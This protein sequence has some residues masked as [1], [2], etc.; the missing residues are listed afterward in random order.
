MAQKIPLNKF[1]SLFTNVQT[2][3]T[4]LYSAP[5]ERATILLNVQ[6][7]NK[8][9]EDITVSFYVSAGKEKITD[10]WGQVYA[11][12]QDLPIPPYDAR[13]LVSGRLVLRGIDGNFYWPDSIYIKASK[14]GIDLSIGLLEA[15]N[16]D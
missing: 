8:T 1:K 6:A 12:V 16:R 9:D 15:V 2:V 11:V 10:P 4:W 5:S 13:A 14:P 7:T 3:S